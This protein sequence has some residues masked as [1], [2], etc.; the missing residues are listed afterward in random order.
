MSKE[1]LPKRIPMTKKEIWNLLGD[2]SLDVQQ[3]SVL[4][5]L[6]NVLGVRKNE[7]LF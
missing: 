2:P 3:R 1:T 6:F 4:V 7:Y 5:D